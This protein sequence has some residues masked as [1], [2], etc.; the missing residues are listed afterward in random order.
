MF[1]KGIVSDQG[2]FSNECLIIQKSNAIIFFIAP[3]TENN[4]KKFGK[5][6][7]KTKSYQKEKRIAAICL[8]HQ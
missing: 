3:K 1:Y 4:V 7:S 8:I 5:A 2:I 6:F